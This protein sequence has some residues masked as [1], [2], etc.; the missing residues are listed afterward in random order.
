MSTTSHYKIVNLSDVVYFQEGPG[1]RNHQNTSNGIRFLNIRCFVD[2]RLDTASMKTISEIEAFGKYKHFLLE[3]GDYVVS[4][5]GTLGRIAEVFPEDLPVLLNT[6]TI[7]FRSTDE[8]QLDRLYLRYFLESEVFQ[9]QVK[10]LAT[11]SVQLNYGP[12]HLAQVEMPLPPIDTQRAIGRTLDEITRKIYLNKTIAHTLQSLAE[13]I[14]Q[15]WFV[16]FEPV[17]A[18]LAGIKPVGVA[19]E[20][21]ALFPDSMEES[22]LG[23]IPTGWDV[24]SVRDFG[25]VVTG[26]T[27]S[28]QKPHYW[29]A[30]IPFVTIPDMHSQLILTSSRRALTQLGA[31]SQPSQ[32]LPRGTTMVSCIA[33]P[34]LISYASMPC[35]ANQQINSVIPSSEN[36][37]AWLFWHMRSLIPQLIRH[38]GIGTVFA[39][40]NKSDFSNIKSTTP[41]KSLRDA[42]SEVATPILDILEN[43]NRQSQTLAEVR[44]ALLPRLISG[45]LE[46][47]EE[48]LAP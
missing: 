17:K 31:D 25:R 26:K 12:S 22:E 37:P 27:P 35:Q 32:N 14:F 18:K 48:M 28:T 45:E 19:D 1:I 5:S 44:D 33:T 10:S 46:I 21:S 39:N 47:P 2:G 34:G 6:S 8:S 29:G 11:G 43:L 24:C 36:P 9:K 4:S 15:S 13:R 7:R 41:P 16:D 20:T 23:P 40:L 42:F 38:S 30:E 3:A